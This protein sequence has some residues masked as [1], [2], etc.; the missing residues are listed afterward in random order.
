[1]NKLPSWLKWGIGTV[2]ISG[3]T[4]LLGLF[5][6]IFVIPGMFVAELLGGYVPDIHLAKLLFPPS[7]GFPG[8]TT[9]GFILC[10]VV[11][12]G[13]GAFVGRVKAIP[14]WSRVV[15]LVMIPAIIFA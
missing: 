12:F 2:V 10:V 9:V 15:I 7:G 3:A 8:L 13:L 6:L 14:A 4:L 11:N 5:G 1:M